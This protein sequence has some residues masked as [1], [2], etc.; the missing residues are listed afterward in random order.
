MLPT[1]L[2]MVRKLK[3]GTSETSHSRTIHG[4][5]CRKLLLLILLR[6][7]TPTFMFLTCRCL[8]DGSSRCL[9]LGVRLWTCGL[10]PIG[11]QNTSSVGRDVLRWQD[12]H[13]IKAPLTSPSMLV[14][15]YVN[16][17]LYSN[18]QYCIIYCF[19]TL[20]CFPAV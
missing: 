17:F 3:K 8:R 13:T 14:D 6:L 16:L 2:S 1:R 15:G 19:L 4:G 11:R 18:S 12:R 9:G 7:D 20:D 10:R 5:K